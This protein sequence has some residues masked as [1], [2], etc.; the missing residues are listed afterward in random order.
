[1]TS[2]AAAAR[3]WSGASVFSAEGERAGGAEPL[4]FALVPSGVGAGAGHSAAVGFL[5]PRPLLGL[6]GVPAVRMPVLLDATRLQGTPKDWAAFGRGAASAG[7]ALL[8]R[9]S[10]S[11]E[12]KDLLKASGAPFAVAVVP[13]EPAFPDSLAGAA[14]VVVAC[15]GLSGAPC[16]LDESALP[17]LVEASR[18]AAG[19][20]CPVLLLVAPGRVPSSGALRAVAEGGAKAVV[21]AEG[22]GPGRLPLAALAGSCASVT[23]ASGELAVG[24]STDG[25]ADGVALAVAL[26]CAPGGLATSLPLRLAVKA[27]ESAASDWKSVGDQLGHALRVLWEDAQR[28]S[29]MAGQR[30]PRDL[31]RENL[32]ALTY[33]AAALSGV[34]LAGFEERLP[35]WAH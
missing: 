18:A 34:K 6:E 35:W 9:P 31:S 33:D 27:G 22:R 10:Q 4:P 3:L 12:R 25:V 15:E 23:A 26:A 13:D 16:V 24:L 28:A 1:M 2:D 7:C 21:L 30:D 11:R 32:R 14:V 5:A 19:Y 29:A 20:R 8:V 17:G